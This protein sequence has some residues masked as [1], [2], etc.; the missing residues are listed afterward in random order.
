MPQH[1]DLELLGVAGAAEQDEELEE[2]ADRQ[3]REREHT[4]PPVDE[5]RGG[6][7]PSGGDR[8]CLLRS[9]TRAEVRPGLCALRARA[10]A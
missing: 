4:S 6:R 9:V 2:S 10:V 7:L 1:E 5:Q 3:V 8:R